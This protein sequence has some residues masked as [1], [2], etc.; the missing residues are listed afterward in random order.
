[1]AVLGTTNVVVS[2][3]IPNVDGR[4]QSLRAACALVAL[5]LGSGGCT[6]PNALR[7]QPSGAPLVVQHAGL[8]PETLIYDAKRDKFLLGSFREGAVYEVDSAGRAARIVDDP[9]LCSVLGI[10][11]DAERNRLWAVNADLGACARPSAA[12]PKQLAGVGVYDLSSGAPLLYADL[13]PLLPGPH[14]L[15]GIALDGGGNAYISDSFSPAIYK[16]DAAGNPSLFLQSEQFRGAGINL[17]GVVVHPD[18]YLLVVKKSDGVLFK[19]PLAE[20]A[21]FSRVLVAERFVG[22][23][24]LVLVGKTELLIVSN[25]VPQQS[26]NSASALSSDDAWASATLR[27]V[28]PLGTAYPTTAALRGGALYVVQS[29]LDELIQAPAERKAELHAQALIRQIGSFAP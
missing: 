3:S 26:A 28:E 25:Q 8:Y 13:A 24:G 11:I 6:R 1:M 22:G 2:Q 20:P 16:V 7:L 15:N 21:R 27:A 14:L 5:L 17:N 10:A 9:R 18:G 29:Q 4:G 12:G 19:I 23:D